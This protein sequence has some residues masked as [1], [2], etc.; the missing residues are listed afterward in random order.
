MKVVLVTSIEYGGPIEHV[1]L[2]A[3]ELVRA[4]AEVRAVTAHR[5]VAEAYAA[6]GADPIVVSGDAA[7]SPRAASTIRR[8]CRGFDVAH[9]HDRRSGLWT[10]G[11]PQGR[12]HIARVHTLHGLPDAYLPLPD[13]LRPPAGLRHR[14]AYRV[15]EARLMG[16]ADA[17]VVPSQATLDLARTLGYRMDRAV[18][19]HNG[20]DVE[21]IVASRGASIG[22]LTAL[23]PVKGIEV[24]LQAAA[25]IHAREPTVRFV[26]FGTGS[27]LALLDEQARR[28]GLGDVVRFA[29]RVTAATAL[30]E[31]RVLVVTSHFET[32]PMAVLE[33]MAAGVPVV[34]TRVGGIAELAPDGAMLIVP[35]NDPAAVAEAIC[36]TIA[37]PDAANARAEEARAHV[38]TARSATATMHAM[39]AVYRGVIDRVQR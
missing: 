27:Q 34:A 26:I 1:R 19:V 35:P 15:V 31:L 20:V 37:D 36:S 33:A 28:L 10:L 8:I 11:W 23:E 14:V 2:L 30:G 25:L 12:R 32:S 39:E 24:F 29:G 5:S 22:M 13:H 7:L 17:V 4:G 9:S 21:W 18:I 3:R 38:R 6:V 16:R